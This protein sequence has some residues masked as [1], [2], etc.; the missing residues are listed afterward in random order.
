M[1]MA[2]LL[3]PLQIYCDFSAYSDIA[4]GVAKLFGIRLTENFDYPLFSQSIGDWWR[5]WHISMMSW[6]RDY[7]YIPLGGG[8]LG[9]ARKLLNIQIVFWVSGLWHGA[10]YHYVMW[11]IEAGLSVAIG[12]LLLGN[13]PIQTL[14]KDV[15]IPSPIQLY[16][17]VQTYLLQCLIWI[18][19]RCMSVHDSFVVYR[20]MLHIF[21]EGALGELIDLMT[22]RKGRLIGLALA[23]PF[24]F[25]EWFQ[26]GRLHPLTLVGVPRPVRWLIYTILLWMII[27]LGATRKEGFVYFQF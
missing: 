22:G 13:R 7:I 24:V 26:R 27:L 19:F 6:F 15:M 4:I 8:R 1:M 23:I 3:N 25:L 10:D 16:R 21:S 2:V 11:G 20:K 17:M 18:V 14:P 5:R 9:M 12:M